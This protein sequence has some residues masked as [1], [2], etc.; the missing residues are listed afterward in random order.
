MPV[1][2]TAECTAL[3][4]HSTADSPPVSSSDRDSRL[5][6]CARHPAHKLLAKLGW[7]TFYDSLMAEIDSQKWLKLVD[8]RAENAPYKLCNYKCDRFSAWSEFTILCRGLLIDPKAKRIVATS[9]P[10]FWNFHQL[11]EGIQQ[12][13]AAQLKTSDDNDDDDAERKESISEHGVFE[14]LDGSLGI[15]FWCEYSNRWRICTRG[16]FASTQAL[17]ATEH[18]GEKLKQH[19]GKKKTTLEK[20]CSYLFEI[21]YKANQIGVDYGDFEGLALIAAYNEKGY[22]FHYESLT[23]L[24]TDLDL[25]VTQCYTAQYGD[26]EA[27]LAAREQIDANQEGFVL[28][29][30]NGFRVKFKGKE[31]LNALKRKKY[32]SPDKLKRRVKA[33]VLKDGVLE[34]D[35]V[36]KEF[37]DEFHG[38]VGK[39]FDEAFAEFLSKQ[40]LSGTVSAVESSDGARTECRSRSKNQRKKQKKK[41]GNQPKKTNSNVRSR[42][43]GVLHNGAKSV[44]KARKAVKHNAQMSQQQRQQMQY[45]SRQLQHNEHMQQMSCQYQHHQQYQ[46]AAAPYAQYN[47]YYAQPSVPAQQPYPYPVYNA[48]AYS[49]YQQ[50][51]M[52]Q[53]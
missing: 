20:G 30:A 32:S 51:P 10:K 38:E 13:I 53:W 34:K 12:H 31:Y 19:G 15:C 33:M 17:W 8:D 47:Q 11:S 24:A 43:G 41:R 48:N 49:A 22:E 16:N 37:E 1:A 28:R 7:N 26:V 21:I 35:S 27:L 44:R 40:Q 29:L 5:N 36:L 39:A 42:G 3:Y 46:A 6:H 4:V 52:H 25:R 9:F 2:L 45:T 50:Q 14:K 18:L 23:Q